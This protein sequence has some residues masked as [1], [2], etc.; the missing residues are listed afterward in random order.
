MSD[1]KARF[2]FTAKIEALEAL[3]Q[4]ASEMSGEPLPL[5]QHQVLEHDLHITRV[6]RAHPYPLFRVQMSMVFDLIVAGKAIAGYEAEKTNREQQN[7]ERRG[8]VAVLESE[9]R[10]IDQ[11]LGWLR[12]QRRAIRD[13]GNGIAWRLFSHDRAILS[14]LA[15]RASSGNIELGGLEAEFEAL[16]QRVLD[17]QPDIAVLNS[18]TNFLNVRR[19]YG[20]ARS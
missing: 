4:R 13:I 11:R 9:I 3:R 15:R 20:A 16:A 12:G 5:E 10:Y 14:V 19:R 17:D 18:L 2:K 1:K 8:D 6:R 7:G